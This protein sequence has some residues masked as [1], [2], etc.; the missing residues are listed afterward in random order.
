MRKE[1]ALRLAEEAEANQ[2][3]AEEMIK[4]AEE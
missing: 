1:E 4:Q 2:K 3:M